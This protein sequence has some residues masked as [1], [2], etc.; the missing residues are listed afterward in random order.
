VL[1][2]V[3]RT[4]YTWLERNRPADVV[5]LEAEEEHGDAVATSAIDTVR[6]AHDSLLEGGV[7]LTMPRRDCP[8][9]LPSSRPLLLRGAAPV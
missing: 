4:C 8:A 3:R 9:F 2:I 6:F 1:K 7:R 5:S